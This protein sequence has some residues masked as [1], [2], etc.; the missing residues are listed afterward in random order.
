MDEK[1]LTIAQAAEYLQ[2]SQSTIRN[3]IRKGELHPL[4]NGRIVRLTV[5]EL[6]RFM[7]GESDSTPNN[8]KSEPVKKESAVFQP[9]SIDLSQALKENQQRKE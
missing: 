9:N 3:R 1:M 5:S 8:R 4:K 6:D 2:C 7:K